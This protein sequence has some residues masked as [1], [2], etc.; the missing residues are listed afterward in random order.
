MK[1]S[2]QVRGEIISYFFVALAGVAVQLIVSSIAQ[3]QFSVQYKNSVAL[4]YAASV[5][6]GFFLTKIFTFKSGQGRTRRQILKY[7]LITTISGFI[8]TYG[9]YYTKAILEAI[10]NQDFVISPFNYSI[11]V[12]ELVSH[13]TGMGFSFIFN[14]VGH[15]FFTFRTTG[16]YEKLNAKFFG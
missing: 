1:K 6:T 8:T 7:L 9:A 5:V 10:F 13:I 3:R 16:F 11:N 4:G 15:K 2:V 14:F 12:I